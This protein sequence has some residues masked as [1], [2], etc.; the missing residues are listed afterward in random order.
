[1][2]NFAGNSTQFTA[3]PL[4]MTGLHF[5]GARLDAFPGITISGNTGCSPHSQMDFLAVRTFVVPTLETERTAIRT[6]RAT[7][8]MA[9]STPDRVIY[10]DLQVNE[11]CSLSGSELTPHSLHAG[12]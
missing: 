8:D 3:V 12:N 7:G 2:L 5:R 10:L 4:D 9:Y 11:H 6:W 1:M